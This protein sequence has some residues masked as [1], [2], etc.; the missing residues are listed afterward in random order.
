MGKHQA[1]KQGIFHPS[2]P[3]KCLNKKGDIVFRSFL[4]YKVMNLCDKNPNVL[5]WSSEKNIVP[6]NHPIE[7]RVARYYIDFYIQLQTESG[8]R[9]CLVEVKPERQ[10]KPP[11]PSNRKKMST[12]LYENVQYA[13]NRAK[14]D[15]AKQYA[16]NKGMEFML[17]TEQ[18]VDRITKKINL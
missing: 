13:I 5:E 12:V 9:K 6:Y 15:A 10:T 11:V 18:D 8:I 16:K 2:N 4:E 17:L 1:Y 3:N 7:K 14:W